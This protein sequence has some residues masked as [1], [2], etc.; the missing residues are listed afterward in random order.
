MDAER[1]VLGKQGRKGTKDGEEERRG[2]Q[3]FTLSMDPA[4]SPAKMQGCAALSLSLPLLATS[5]TNACC[6]QN[7]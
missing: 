5:S 4:C 2:E 7:I 1:E 3:P 6:Q